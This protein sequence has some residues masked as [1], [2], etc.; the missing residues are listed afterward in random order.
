MCSP[1]EEAGP[2]KQGPQCRFDSDRAGS[3]TAH[4]LTHRALWRWMRATV[5]RE[6]TRVL[7]WPQIIRCVEASSVIGSAA[8]LIRYGCDPFLRLIAGLTVILARDERTRAD[9]A[10][11]VL[12]SYAGSRAVQPTDRRARRLARRAR[13]LTA[14]AAQWMQCGCGPNR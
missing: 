14:Q 12:R 1:R 6:G 9:R 8:A 7:H 3:L 5:R 11:E 4:L 13:G 10:L 2:F